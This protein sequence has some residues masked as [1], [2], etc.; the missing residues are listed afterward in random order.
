MLTE[1]SLLYTKHLYSGNIQCGMIFLWEQYKINFMNH[2]TIWYWTHS[3]VSKPWI[4]ATMSN[5]FDT[6]GQ[7][8]LYHWGRF[9]WTL[10]LRLHH[11]YWYPYSQM[12]SQPCLNMVIEVSI[13]REIDL[14]SYQQLCLCPHPQEC[15]WWRIFWQVQQ[16]PGSCSGF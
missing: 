15:K 16:V 7:S 6:N 9:W 2:L 8:K 14:V 13:N 12:S 1:T 11:F 5:G 10:S 4:W 3:L